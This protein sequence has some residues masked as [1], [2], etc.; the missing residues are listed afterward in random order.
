MPLQRPLAA[1]LSL[2]AAL[3]RLRRAVGPTP[4]HQGIIGLH[5]AL[6]VAAGMGDP[7]AAALVKLPQGAPQ[8]A[9]AA[10]KGQLEG[11]LPGPPVLLHLPGRQR[12]APALSPGIAAAEELLPLPSHDAGSPGLPGN[13]G[14]SDDQEGHGEPPPVPSPVFQSHLP[15]LNGMQ[16]FQ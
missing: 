16:A 11:G 1:L 9:A 10:D 7:V 5:A 14:P 8:A 2:L 3:Q 6:D 12:V 15:W 4:D 13:D